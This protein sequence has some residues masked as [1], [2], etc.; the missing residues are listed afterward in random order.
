MKTKKYITLGLIGL[1]FML[2]TSCSIQKR[3]YRK[4]FYVSWNKNYSSNL[5]NNKTNIKSNNSDIQTLEIEKKTVIASKNIT[6]KINTKQKTKKVKDINKT[7]EQKSLKDKNEPIKKVTQV[8]QN[9]KSKILNF[10]PSTPEITQNEILTDSIKT[11]VNDDNPTDGRIKN[12]LLN[13]ANIFYIIGAIAIFSSPFTSLFGIP[14]GILLFVIGYFYAIFALKRIKE[15][16]KKFLKK[17]KKLALIYIISY[18]AISILSLIFIFI[19]ALSD[20]FLLLFGFYPL[21]FI[22][23]GLI[24]LIILNIKNKNS[25]NNEVIKNN[26]RKRIVIFLSIFVSLLI[27]FLTFSIIS[28]F[29]I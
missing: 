25:K 24:G 11:N 17:D 22:I 16:P 28:I 13:Y 23:I 18:N 27:A 6:V 29:T 26:K 19:I 14:L 2:N 7:I 1:I 8:K 5:Q 4:G 10:I 9:K 21:F 15:N 3:R 12:H 20:I